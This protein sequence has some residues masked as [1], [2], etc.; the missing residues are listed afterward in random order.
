[1]QTLSQ[2]GAD[3]DQRA[4]PGFRTAV[5]Y[6]LQDLENF[7]VG[8]LDLPTPQLRAEM[9]QLAGS[10]VGLENERL[11]ALMRATDTMQDRALIRPR[12]NSR[13]TRGHLGSGGRFSVVRRRTVETR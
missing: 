8:R 6:A 10:A 12:P 4:Q 2:R 9:T 5:A 11:Q 3:A 1:M 7:H 13:V